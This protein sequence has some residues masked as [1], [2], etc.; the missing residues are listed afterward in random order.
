MVWNKK[1]G[2]RNSCS[3]RAGGNPRHRSWEIEALNYGVVEDSVTRDSNMCTTVCH[4]M[5]CGYHG[6]KI[7]V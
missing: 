4:V 5:Q 2:D 1:A 3:F 7:A 6:F